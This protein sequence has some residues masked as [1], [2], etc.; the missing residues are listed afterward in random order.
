MAVVAAVCLLIIVVAIIC[1]M[2]KRKGEWNKDNGYHSE[3]RQMEPFLLDNDSENW[4]N[5]AVSSNSLQSPTIDFKD[6][7]EMCDF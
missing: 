6:N 4:N 2:R 5:E 7:T 1:R 3:G